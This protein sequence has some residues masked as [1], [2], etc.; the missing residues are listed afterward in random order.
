[1]K[2]KRIF[3]AAEI[4]AIKRLINKKVIATKEQQQR[5]RDEIRD[6]Y[7]FYYSEFSSKKGYTISD[8]QVLIDTK[9]II[10]VENSPTTSIVSEGSTPVELTYTE[11]NPTSAHRFLLI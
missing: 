8:L 2:G 7:G 9:K 3:T 5:I 4:D 6:D 11:K 10:V 1:M